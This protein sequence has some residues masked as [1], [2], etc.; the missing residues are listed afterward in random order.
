MI[1]KRLHLRLAKDGAV[2]EA[3][4][5]GRPLYPLLKRSGPSPGQP[6]TLWTPLDLPWTLWTPSWTPTPGLSTPLKLVLRSV[7]TC[8]CMAERR[9][10]RHQGQRF[11]ESRLCL[12]FEA[13][14]I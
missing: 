11:W 12:R 5:S 7:W 1:L 6:W 14:T 4:A 3:G 8:A 9:L 13:G 2:D 10:M